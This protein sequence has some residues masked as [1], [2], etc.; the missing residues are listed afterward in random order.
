MKTSETLDQLATA[1]AAAQGQFT[2]PEKNRD[3]DVESERAKYSFAYATLDAVLDMVRPHLMANGLSIVQTV[4]EE[5]APL[6]DSPHNAIPRLITRLLHS[7]GQWIEGSLRMQ[8]ER[9]GNQ[10]VGSA[11]TYMR[12]YGVMAMLG[13]CSATDDDDGNASDGNRAQYRDRAPRQEQRREAP[14]AGVGAAPTVNKNP[15]SAPTQTKP[16]A[17]PTSVPGA[18][19]DTRPR[20][21]DPAKPKELNQVWY[22]CLFNLEGE[23]FAVAVWKNAKASWALR[24]ETMRDITLA[25]EQIRKT[26]GAKPGSELIGSIVGSFTM[27]PDGLQQI[28][29]ELTRASL[30]DVSMNLEA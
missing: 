16:T 18:I 19:S 1:L 4:D 17:S 27:D 3:V 2:S 24:F 9:G 10:G 14:K 23:N 13:I 26:I 25:C 15:T 7:S 22:D 6:P 11:I 12:R 5:P 20:T 8:I 28:R 30:G 21:F 29:K